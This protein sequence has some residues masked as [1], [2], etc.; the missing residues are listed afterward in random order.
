MRPSPCTPA[1]PADS[2]RWTS[3]CSGRSDAPSAARAAVAELIPT[4]SIATINAGWRER[5]A[6]D[7]ELGEVLGGRM[8]NLRLYQR[9]SELITADAEYAAA[10]R[11]LTELT[12]RSSRRSTR[13]GCS[14][15]SRRWTR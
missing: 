9:W 3:P 6:G 4:G 10:E 13:C 7:A 1:E 11:K 5:E 12:W 8:V 14:T 2:A 15:R